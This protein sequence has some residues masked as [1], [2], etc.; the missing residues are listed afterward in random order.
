M[1]TTREIKTVVITPPNMQRIEFQLVGTTPFVMHKFAAKAREE[2][3]QKQIAGSTAKAKKKREP[4]DFEQVYLDAHHFSYD[5]W[6][7]I[8]ASAFRSA[9]ISAC[10]LV[11]FVMTRAK[12]A[13][14]IHH[15]GIDKDDGTPLVRIIG[16]PRRHETYVRLETGVV[17]IRVRPMWEEWAVN[18]QID[19]D[20]D[21]FTADDIANLLQRA[22]QQV[23]IGEGRPD[24]KKSNGI[25]WG[26]FKIKS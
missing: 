4:K 8:P 11:G 12:L 17:D 5:D 3:M 18:L 24:S 26:T 13:I 10:K 6:V 25:V 14:F 2:I 16:T 21:V 7:G 22:G 1:A 19:Y 23:G 15:D 20:A 9:M